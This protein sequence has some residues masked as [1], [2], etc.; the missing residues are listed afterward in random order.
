MEQTHH[1]EMEYD[2]NLHAIVISKYIFN[3]NRQ[4]FYDM[5]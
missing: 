5:L 3:I 2:A 4:H 1:E